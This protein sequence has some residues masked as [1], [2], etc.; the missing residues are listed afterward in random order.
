VFGLLPGLIV[1][2]LAISI[3]L[4]PIFGFRRVNEWL[5]QRRHTP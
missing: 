1:G 3:A 5:Q 2:L 4:Y